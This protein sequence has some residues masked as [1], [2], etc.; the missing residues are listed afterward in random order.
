MFLISKN[1]Y[2]LLL[3]EFEKPY[4]KNLDA[5]LTKEYATKTIYPVP[6][7]VFNSI[8]HLKYEDVKVVILGQDPYHEPNQAHGF[9]FSVENGVEL[10]PSLKNIFKEIQAEYGFLNTN[11]NL[12]NWVKQGVLLLNSVL[13]VEKGRANSHKD[14]GWE[15]ITQKIVELLNSRNTPIVFLLWGASAQKIGKNITN[16]IHKIFSCAHPS[17]LSAYNGFFGCGHFKKTNEFLK[18]LGKTEID[19]RT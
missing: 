2:E 8:N 6:E 15:N 18:S 11:G 9:A 19:W 7:K 10:P 13:T 16:P 17:P 12:T 5:F 4:Y 14:K 1:W 3:D